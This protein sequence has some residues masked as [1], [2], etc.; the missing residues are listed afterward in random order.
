MSQAAYGVFDRT[1]ALRCALADTLHHAHR[2]SVYLYRIVKQY[3]GLRFRYDIN[4]CVYGCSFY[5]R[6]AG[7][8]RFQASLLQYAPEESQLRAEW[9]RLVAA[10]ARPGTPLHQVRTPPLHRFIGLYVGSVHV[11]V[12]LGCRCTCSRWR[13]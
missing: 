11:V 12:M 5:A 9:G 2:R 7:W 4:E 13:T 10:A 3:C 6:W 8:E 1:N